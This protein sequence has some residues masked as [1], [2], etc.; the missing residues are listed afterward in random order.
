MSISVGDRIPAVTLKTPTANGIEDLSTGDFFAGKKVVLFAVPGAFTPTCSDNHLPSFVD[1]ADQI[2][3]R[4]VDAIAC[5]AVND[6]FVLAAW[7]HSRGAEGKVTMLADGN[8]DFA[9]ALGM[10]LDA[11]DF[12]LGTRSQRYAA[13]VEDGIVRSWHVEENPGEMRLSAATVI[14]DA[15]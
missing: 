15:L 4:G 8:G 9:R 10:E 7:A 3:A 1:H 11:S 2:L 13:I 6:A 12:G 5:T 14:L